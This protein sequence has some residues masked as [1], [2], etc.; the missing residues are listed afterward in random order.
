M[1]HLPSIALLV[2]A[3]FDGRACRSQPPSP[4]E[5]SVPSTSAPC[6]LAL[7]TLPAGMRV[8]DLSGEFR[9]TLVATSGTSTG[10][11][12]SG[13]LR[14]RRYDA[15]MP[16]PPGIAARPGVRYLVHGSATIA[17]DSVGASAP[18]DISSTDPAAPGVLGMEWS[19]DNTA[20][21]PKEITLRFGADA[22]RGGPVRFEGTYMA[23]H[24]RDLSADRFAG[25][26]T[27]GA[28]MQRAAGHFCAERVAT[29]Q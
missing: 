20:A 19:R 2:L 17:L 18:G 25:S 11:S 24:L 16:G 13:L 22:N 3:G 4:A 14:L 10:R 21:G 1:R 26:W 12:T 23:L 29:R 27:S 28:G 6:A 7:G 15:A 9:L 5:G 8:D